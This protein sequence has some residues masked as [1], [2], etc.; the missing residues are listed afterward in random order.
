M[1]PSLLEVPRRFEGSGL[2]LRAFEPGDG[3]ALFDAIDRSRDALR[4]WLPWVDAHAARGDSEAWAREAS[5][6]FTLREDLSFAV[7]DGAGALVGGVG[8]HR[9]DLDVGRFE[10][11]YWVRA[12]RWRGGVGGRAAR[13]LTSLAFVALGAARVEARIDAR[14]EP[15]ARLARSLGMRHE[16]TLRRDALGA[17]GAHRDTMV[18]SMLADEHARAPW[19][20]ATYASKLATGCA[21]TLPMRAC[22]RDS[23]PTTA[24]RSAS[25]CP[26]GA[27]AARSRSASGRSCTT[28]PASARPRSSAGHPP[29]RST[30]R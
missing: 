11:G 16:G 14:N 8:L 26:A 4:P 9:F 19:A 3:L 18:F 28:R 27:R 15:S 12:D 17:D 6:R 29:A 25:C 10:L 22:T 2:V 21:V 30:A 13:E 1:R 5:A 7:L 20:A 23:S 24:L